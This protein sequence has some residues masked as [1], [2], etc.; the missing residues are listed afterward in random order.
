MLAKRCAKAFLLENFSR[1]TKFSSVHSSS[2]LFCRGVPVSSRHRRQR[3]LPIQRD[4]Y[5]HT[6][7]GMKD[8]HRETHG[9]RARSAQR[10]E[11]AGCSYRWYIVASDSSLKRGRIRTTPENSHCREASFMMTLWLAKKQD[12]PR[13]F[14]MVSVRHVIYLS[15]D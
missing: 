14:Q 5:T 6:Q 2:V 12:V 11:H 7:T 9:R 3:S 10:W 13:G 15:A 1:S 4:T 8:T